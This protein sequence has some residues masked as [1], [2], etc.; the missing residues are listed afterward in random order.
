MA[1]FTREELLQWILML[2]ALSIIF[3]FPSLQKLPFYFAASVISLTARIV[4]AKIAA[5]KLKAR[6]VVTLSLP[7]SLAGIFLSFIGL[8]IC[9]VGSAKPYAYKFGRWN[10]KEVRL[11]TKEEG[12]ISLVATL[13]TASFAVLFQFMGL[14]EL[15]VLNAWLLFSSLLPAKDLDGEMILKWDFGIWFFF[16]IISALMVFLWI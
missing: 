12:I 11:S 5:E 2:I 10:R 1:L 3:A 16:F 4:A 13:T 6:A 14:K 9:P 7:G 15:S 8:K